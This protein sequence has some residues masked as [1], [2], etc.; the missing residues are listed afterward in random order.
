MVY[1]AILLAFVCGGLVML[2]IMEHSS[3][4]KED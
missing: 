3:Y 2:Y 1:V 4:A